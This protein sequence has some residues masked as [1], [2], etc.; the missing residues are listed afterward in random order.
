MLPVVHTSYKLIYEELVTISPNTPG[1]RVLNRVELN[2]A[3][4]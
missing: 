2:L 3:I 1:R 4:F